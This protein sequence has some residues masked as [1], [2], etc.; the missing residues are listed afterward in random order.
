MEGMGLGEVETVVFCGYAAPMAEGVGAVLG[1]AL[2][3]GRLKTVHFRRVGFYERLLGGT[4][5]TTSTANLNP[6]P[7]TK[8]ARC[9]SALI[10]H[11]K[12]VVASSA[13][14]RVERVVLEACVGV[15]EEDVRELGKFVGEVEVVCGPGF[16]FGFGPL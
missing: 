2:A 7:K 1:D 6:N 13:Y 16:G 12:D 10:L 3:Q 11:L 8:K 4:L 15:E 5:P 14:A 9:R